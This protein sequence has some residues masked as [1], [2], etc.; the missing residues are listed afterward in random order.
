MKLYKIL[1]PVFIIGSLSLSAQTAVPEQTAAVTEQTP[2]AVPEQTPAAVEVPA[3]TAPA[4]IPA[5]EQSTVATSEQPAAPTEQASTPPK[6][7]KVKTPKTKPAPEQNT[8]LKKAN[9]YYGKQSYA[10]AIPFYE[11][12]M[13]ADK[14]NKVILSNLG[15]CY[16]LTNNTKGQL[17]CFGELIKNGS[18]EPIQELYYG[19]ALV[20]NG[21]AEKAKS[22]FEKYAADT[23]GQ[24]LASS[25]S[26]AKMYSKNADAYAIAEVAYN[27]PAK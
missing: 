19:Q 13:L 24:N 7:K 22:F 4:T 1:L 8:A 16:R 2:A 23:R 18:A 9:L 10:E 3:S 15:E 5:T 25:L 17:M 20:E 26:K 27:T 14:N 12:A 21:E 11:K 6:E